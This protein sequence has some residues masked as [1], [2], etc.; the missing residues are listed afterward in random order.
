MV[1]QSVW[2]MWHWG[3]GLLAQAS[4][5]TAFERMGPRDRARV[6]A[7]LGVILIL[8][9]FLILFVRLTARM[10]RRYMN[11]TPFPRPPIPRD[12]WAEKP[13]NPEPTRS[14]ASAVAAA[15]RAGAD[16]DEEWPADEDSDQ[17]SDDESGEDLRGDDD[18]T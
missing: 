3:A 14:R 16:E 12:D 9:L 17:D 5:Q 10:I 7:A 18:R 6:L 15:D 1:S 2:E 8:A 4:T 11:P 13:L